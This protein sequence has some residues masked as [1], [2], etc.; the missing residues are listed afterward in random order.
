MSAGVYPFWRA[1]FQ[2]RLPHVGW[3]QYAT[4][5]ATFYQKKEGRIRGIEREKPRFHS[6]PSVVIRTEIE[7]ASLHQIIV[8]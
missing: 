7:D 8:V 5:A 4:M 6:F 1:I 2:A 3:Q